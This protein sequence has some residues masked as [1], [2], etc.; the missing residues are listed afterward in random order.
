[1][2]ETETSPPRPHTL[3]TLS[4]SYGLD[5]ALW[6]ANKRHASKD[7]QTKAMKAGSQNDGGQRV[8]GATCV[9][10]LQALS[11]V[12]TASAQLPSSNQDLLLPGPQLMFLSLFL[13]GRKY[14][15]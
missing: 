13:I 9:R 14:H 3:Q 6:E 2:K 15:T 11:E 12:C 1:M 4:R 8:M 7:Y 5:L 10:M